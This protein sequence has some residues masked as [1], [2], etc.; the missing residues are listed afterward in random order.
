M[1]VTTIEDLLAIERALREDLSNPRAKEITLPKGFFPS[2]I[3]L[4]DVMVDSL[5]RFWDVSG[6]PIKM[7]FDPLAFNRKKGT[8]G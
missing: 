8:K 1:T 5:G 7:I 6:T 4:R 2:Q 3:G